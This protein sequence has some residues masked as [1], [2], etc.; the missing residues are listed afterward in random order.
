MSKA[1]QEMGHQVELITGKGEHIRYKNIPI[2]QFAFTP[3]EKILDLGNRFRKWGE[4]ISFFKNAYSYIKKEKYDLFLVHKP[5]DFFACFFMKKVNPNIKTVFV[6]GGEDFYGFDKYFSRYVDIMVSVSKDNAEKISKRY[7]KYVHTV[8]NGVDTDIFV[9]DR[10]KSIYI[11]ERYSLQQ[12][13][14]LMSVGRV[15]G[16]KGF[17]IVIQSLVELEDFYYVLIGDGDYLNELRGLVKSLNLEERVLLMG[18]IEHKNLPD[19]LA[20]ADIFVQPSIGHEAFGITIIE[21]MSMSIPVVASN[22]GGIKDIIIDGINGYLFEI[23][24]IEEMIEKIKICYEFKERISEEARKDVLS[25]FTWTSSM[26]KLIEI[27]RK[28]S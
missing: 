23:N 21:A 10:E 27:I 3:R 2:K 15:V 28:N 24:N 12:K 11:R 6:S 19:Y 9:K 22:N 8:P 5:L 17:Q 1:L 20:M 26:D 16:W 18:S 4:R 7:K 25:K 14:V 13:K